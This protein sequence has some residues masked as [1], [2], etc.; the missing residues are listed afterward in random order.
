[1]TRLVEPAIAA[2][3]EGVEVTALAVVV[4]RVV[5]PIFRISTPARELITRPSGQLV[6]AGDK[7]H[8]PAFA[9]AL[10][11]LARDG[12][13]LFYEGEMGASLVKSCQ[14]EGGQLTFDDLLEYECLVREPLHCTY[15]G[16]DV[17]LNP[18]P[19]AGGALVGFGLDLLADTDLAAHRFGDVGHVAAL[20]AAIHATAKARVDVGQG[21]ERDLFDAPL[22][23]RYR[24][25]VAGAP[26]STRGTTH[27]SVV[28]EAGSA[29]GLTLS[30]GEGCGH[31]LDRTGIMLNNVLGEDDVNPAGFHAW[32]AQTRL[33]SM[34]SP[35]LLVWPDGRCCALGSGG[36]KRIRSALLQAVVNIVDFGLS[37]DQAVRRPRLHAELDLLD[38][39]PGYDP[40][41]I[42]AAAPAGLAVRAWPAENLFFG[43]VHL[44]MRD[45]DGSVQG[46]GDPRR[47]GVFRGA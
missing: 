12:D 7:I 11:A 40:Q 43:G 20:A 41:A 34:M 15:R 21:N 29:V 19:A 28:D 4:A 47:G 13:R 25:L 3:R 30:N 10:D 27:V 31:L 39:E 42:K 9:S 26:A 35:G 37:P 8:N 36:S 17:W 38:H 1:M 24:K 23:S 16:V 45:A 32:P 44:V 5:E 2:A 46:G 33:S 6:E 14:E 18:P 22:L